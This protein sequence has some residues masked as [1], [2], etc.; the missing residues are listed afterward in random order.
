MEF[1]RYFP[2]VVDGVEGIVKREPAECGGVYKEREGTHHIHSV[3]AAECSPNIHFIQPFFEAR[4][5]N[6]KAVP[7]TRH[8]FTKTLVVG[9]SRRNQGSIQKGKNKSMGCSQT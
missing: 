5:K 3:V 1:L 9:S 2:H 6:V 7:R 4:W 8:C